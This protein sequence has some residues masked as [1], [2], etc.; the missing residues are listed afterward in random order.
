MPRSLSFT[1]ANRSLCELLTLTAPMGLLYSFAAGNLKSL[2]RLNNLKNSQN[3]SIRVGRS[4]ISSERS[5]RLAFVA[6]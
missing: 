3:W 5:E 4:P 2:K 1:N 6:A